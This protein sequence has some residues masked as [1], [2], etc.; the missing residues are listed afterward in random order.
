MW[1]DLIAALEGPWRESLLRAGL[2]LRGPLTLVRQGGASAYALGSTDLVF[3]SGA[4]QP[5]LVLQAAR[6]LAAQTRLAAAREAL[7]DACSI[8]ALEGTVP[9]PVGLFPM[10]ER[11][12]LVTT[13]PKGSALEVLLGRGQR[14]RESQVRH[15][16]FRAQV[17][18]QLLQEAT[19][20]GVTR[21]GGR[22]AVRERQAL[23]HHAG[24]PLAGALRPFAERVAEAA[25]PYAGLELPLT[26]CHGRFEPA[27][28]LLTD[29]RIAVVDWAQFRSDMLPFEDIFRFAAGLAIAHPQAGTLADPRSRFAEAFLSENAFSSLM[30]EYVERYMRAMHLPPGLALPLF[31]IFLMDMAISEARALGA[32]QAMGATPGLGAAWRDL[33]LFYAERDR[34][35]IFHR[36]Q[37]AAPGPAPTTSPARSAA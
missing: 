5:A 23:L 24:L 31:G 9:R 20:S 18:L 34:A 12:V 30:L 28:V 29:D 8:S 13:A 15:D 16:L 19:A 1:P 14:T 10:G 37:P 6:G 4:D 25:E 26:G 2:R 11:A 27:T 35:S 22:Q 32:P 36:L 21:F 3:E 33:L 7:D 17:W